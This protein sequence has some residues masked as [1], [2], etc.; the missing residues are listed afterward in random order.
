ML[1]VLTT[2]GSP[3]QTASGINTASAAQE[4]ASAAQRKRGRLRAEGS[5]GANSEGMRSTTRSNSRF[6]F[7]FKKNRFIPSPP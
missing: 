3:A 1:P 2:A 6:S 4:A 5:S 7:R